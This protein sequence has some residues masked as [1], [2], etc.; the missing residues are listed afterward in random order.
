MSKKQKQNTDYS[1]EHLTPQTW[2]ITRQEPL[3][4]SDWSPAGG[5]K[6]DHKGMQTD[7]SKHALQL[8]LKNIALG[9]RL[10][11]TRLVLELRQSSDQLVRNAGTKIRTGR[12]WKAEDCVDSAISRL[13]HQELVGRIQQGRRGLGWGEPQ[14]FWSKASE[15]ERKELLVT[16]VT[17]MEEDKFLVKSL[18]QRQQGQWTKWE[19]IL[20]RPMGWSDLWKIPQA[21]LSFLIRATYDTLPN[22]ANLARWFGSEENCGL[23][24]MAQVNLQHTQDRLGTGS[25]QVAA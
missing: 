1:T 9:Y 6:I 5:A 2:Q 22:L 10:E 16:E 21:R 7:F 4:T 13:K 20:P 14:K 3:L 8:P 23:C 11:K 18:S 25:L 24:E 17:R 19:G 12:A 15:K